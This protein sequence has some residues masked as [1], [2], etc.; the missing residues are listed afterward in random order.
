M[1][2]NFS[3]EKN[4]A[5][6][7]RSL[8]SSYFSGVES[9]TIK[10]L[11]QL[12]TKDRDHVYKLYYNG[13]KP[14]QFS[15]FH[16]INAEY[17]QTRIP[18][19][20][21]H[22]GLK[23]LG[24][25]KLERLMGGCD[26]LVMPNWNTWAVGALTRVV[27]TVHDLSPQ[28]LPEYYNLKARLWH[29]YLNVP[30]LIKRADQLIAVSDFTKNSLM[31]HYGIPD[32]KITVA[33]PGVDH[34]NYRPNLT[35]PRLREVRN[36]YRLPGDF[37]LYVGTIEP[38]KNL[39]RLLQAFEALKEPLHLVIAGKLGWK[40]DRLLWRIR[41]SPKRR[42]IHLLGYV[43]EADKPYILKLARML[44]WPSLYEGFGMPIIEAMAVGTPVLTSNVSSL[45]EVA[46]DAALLVNPYATGEI[47]AGIAT[48]HTNEPVRQQ[49][50]AKG[51]ER[52]QEFTW[53]K[54]A[55]VIKSVLSS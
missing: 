31:K 25:P 38:R 27:L 28:L 15:S 24:W 26:V 12:L 7:L 21:L 46:G 13:F 10:V 5:V 54:C 41:N 23:F 16:F 45:P 2:N 17:I 55:Q 20:L 34:E 3:P 1:R 39:E 32:E 22:L 29:R 18:N 37:V 9:Y 14:K 4:I 30:K 8:H 35:I 49:Y 47:T 36:S 51:L 53:E 48:L 33:R 50:I 44:V 6:D 42:Q 19:R 52:S 11:E 40:Y 43:P